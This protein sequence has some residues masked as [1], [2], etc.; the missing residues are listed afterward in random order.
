MRLNIITLFLLLLSTLCFGQSVQEIIDQVSKDGIIQAVRDFSGE[1]STV[2]NGNKV[3]IRNR[4]NGTTGNDLAAD[5]LKEQ[6]TNFGLS[7][8]DDA[9]SSGGRNIYA[10]QTGSLNPNNIFIICGHY[11][12]V[13]DYC[14][15]DNA[16][17]TVTVLEAARI[18]SNYEIENTVIYALWDE[19]ESGLKGARE[20]ANKAAQN[21]DNIVAVLNMDMMAYDSNNDK[22]FDIDVR[23]IANSYQI[24]D[25]LIALVDSF[26]F[27]LIPLVVDP[28]TYASDH[29][30][31]WDVGYSA[32][33]FGES[34]ETGDMNSEY[35]TSDD[36]ISLFNVDYYFEMVKLAVAY[37]TYKAV[38]VP[39]SSFEMNTASQ[40]KIY[41]NPTK[42]VVN[43]DLGTIHEGKLELFSIEGQLLL[44]QKFN[45]QFL[46]LDMKHLAVGNY[47]L[48]FEDVE[49]KIISFK[50]TKD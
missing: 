14:A 30:P 35:H 39:I 41:P 3:L 45:H 4:E 5:Y 15:D 43:I 38:L 28:G 47:V 44:E 18:L 49:G 42:D 16:S 27:D 7:V 46:T 20:F 48:R 10:T 17:G 31:F 1:D 33:L 36:R 29:K 25:D 12:S 37:I 6:L 21:G 19:A 26:N 50:V 23:N 22:V 13:A 34:W 2:V 11:D 40:I 32:V 24:R 8:T 9:Y